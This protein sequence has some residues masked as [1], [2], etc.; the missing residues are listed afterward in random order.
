M[1]GRR[2]VLSAGGVE[3]IP[4]ERVTVVADHRLPGLLAL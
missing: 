4:D 1:V 2:V 3:L